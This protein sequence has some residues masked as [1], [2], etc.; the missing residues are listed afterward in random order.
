MS[1]TNPTRPGAMSLLDKY[2]AINASIEEARRRVAST[3]SELE[4]A[5]QRIENLQNDRRAMEV[6]TKVAKEEMARFEEELT[7]VKIDHTKKLDEKQRIV[8]E[9]RLA[10]D[11]NSNAKRHIDSERLSF[12]ERC[13][14]FRSSCKRMKVAATL[15]V[16]DGGGGFDKEDDVWRRLQEDDEESAHGKKKRGDDVEM[17]RVAKGEK[18][19]REAFIEAE[20]A[21]HAAKAEHEQAVERCDARNQKLTQQRAQLG[22]HR[23]EVEELEKEIGA[24]KDEIVKA[25]QDAKNY[26]NCEYIPLE[27]LF[28]LTIL[29]KMLLQ[30][31][32]E[33][34]RHQGT[35]TTKP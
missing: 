10:R 30:L 26:E 33:D 15:L 5:Q 11:E 23:R 32:R 6:E 3:R 4:S 20:C 17:D 35:L 13:R 8:G 28:S 1:L 12:L 14:E 18:E 27:L 7:Q 22:R 21:L 9:H 16:L 2:A 24:V 34:K 25:N 29:L 19:Q 31:G